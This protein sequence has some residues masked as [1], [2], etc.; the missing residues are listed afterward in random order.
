M[1]IALFC[2]TFKKCIYFTY[3]R[4]PIN[5]MGTQQKCQPTEEQHNP[6]HLAFSQLKQR[7]M[8]TDNRETADCTLPAQHD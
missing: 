4:G 2:T 7:S 6:E 5:N 3:Q 1:Q 8:N